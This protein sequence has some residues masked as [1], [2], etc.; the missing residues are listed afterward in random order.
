M[1][2][3]KKSRIDPIN[4]YIAIGKNDKKTLV[5][6]YNE[7]ISSKKIGLTELLAINFFKSSL[8]LLFKRLIYAVITNKYAVYENKKDRYHT[9]IQFDEVYADLKEMNLDKLEML[10]HEKHQLIINELEKILP[11]H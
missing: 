10:L 9:K 8:T 2:V 4:N 7:L 5:S 3:E 1:W 11:S 6:I